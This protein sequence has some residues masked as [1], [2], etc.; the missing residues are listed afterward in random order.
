MDDS[1]STR[2]VFDLICIL[3]LFV[4][5]MFRIILAMD[6]EIGAR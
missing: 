2:V 3:I 1:R 6:G 4:K 5:E